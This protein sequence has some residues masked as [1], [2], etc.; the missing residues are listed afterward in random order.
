MLLCYYLQIF[1]EIKSSWGQSMLEQY[2]K[3]GHD[4]LV[5]MSTIVNDHIKI[6]PCLFDP[7]IQRCNIFLIACYV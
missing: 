3:R 2:I 7:S 4:L 5:V 6:T 1:Q